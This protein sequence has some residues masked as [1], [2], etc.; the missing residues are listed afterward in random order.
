MRNNW[1]FRFLGLHDKKQKERTEDVAQYVHKKKNKF[2]ADM[3]DIQIRAKHA[4]N[5]AKKSLKHAQKTVRITED[6]TQ[7]LA[8]VTEK[9]RL[10]KK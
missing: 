3:L 4:H 8:I 10:E 6:I 1:L 7:R 5:E 2:T 9:R